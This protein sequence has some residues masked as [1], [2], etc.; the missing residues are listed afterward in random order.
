MKKVL[1]TLSRMSSPVK[2]MVAPEWAV[3]DA[4]IK[5]SLMATN[6]QPLVLTDDAPNQARVIERA[7]SLA[8]TS[9]S[10]LIIV[11]NRKITDAEKIETNVKLADLRGYDWEKIGGWLLKQEML[12]Q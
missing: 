8:M 1:I 11:A 3:S 10:S 4:R 7:V 6:V 9:P 5:N 12:K 2:P